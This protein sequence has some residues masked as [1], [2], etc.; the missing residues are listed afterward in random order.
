MPGRSALDRSTIAATAIGI[1]DR[2]GPDGVSMRR[3][4]GELGVSAMALYNHVAGKQEVLDAVAEHVLAEVVPP[5][6]ALPWRDRVE[7]VLLGLRAAYRRH[8][9]AMP[10]VQTAGSVAPV[11]LQP[12]EA[13]L[14]ALADGGVAPDAAL[15][16]WS[17]LVGLANGHVAYELRGHLQREDR[18]AAPIDATRF[19]HVIGALDA[20]VNW[21]RAFLGGLRGVLD[22]A[23]AR[24]R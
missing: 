16:L 7:G 9:R 6:P 15:E 12:M 2:D 4:A 19:P 1:V 17:V 24:H 20:D 23:V 5:D 21:D 10:L 13:V 22:A 8:P 14:A 3:L 11:T 18:R